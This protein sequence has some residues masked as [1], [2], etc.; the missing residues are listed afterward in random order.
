[1]LVVVEEEKKEVV[2][3]VVVSS[4]EKAVEIPHLRI[5]YGFGRN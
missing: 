4:L 3:V 5:F 1:M 2:L